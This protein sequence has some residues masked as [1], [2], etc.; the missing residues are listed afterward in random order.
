MR[1]LHWQVEFGYR[2]LWWS[3]VQYTEIQCG[4][5]REHRLRRFNSAKP[6]CCLGTE[7]LF[8]VTVI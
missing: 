5:H 1:G 4:P 3:S 7:S 8:I 6:T 2:H